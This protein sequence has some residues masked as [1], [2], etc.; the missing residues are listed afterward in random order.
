MLKRTLLALTLLVLTMGG[1]CSITIDPGGDDGGSGT[2]QTTLDQAVAAITITHPVG[3]PNASVSATIKDSRNRTVTLRGDQA[4]EVNDVALAGPNSTGRYTAL[5]APA[6][7]YTLRV[8]EPT[9]GVQSTV[10][11]G[12]TDFEV[13]APTDNGTVSLSG[14]TLLWSNP[15]EQHQVTIELSQTVF[16]S[17]VAKTF[18]PFGDSGTHTFTAS[19]LS[20]FVHGTNL[21][22]AIELTKTASTNSVSGFKSGTMTA[23]VTATRTA[24]PRP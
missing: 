12:P 14:F 2:T 13:T 15:D 7:Q 16:G 9:I 4:V 3:D 6:A 5:V 10:L 21:A 20:S 19:D 22:L 1:S 11:D 8:H 23:Q 17:P 18:G 24:V